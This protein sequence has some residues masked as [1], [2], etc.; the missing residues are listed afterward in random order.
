MRKK[1]TKILGVALPVVLVFALVVGFVPALKSSDADAAAG[2]MRFGKVPLPKYGAAGKY[3]LVSDQNVGPLAVT[4]DGG[5]LFA[6]TNTSGAAF[7]ALLKSS[8]G[9]DSWN[10][11]SGFATAAAAQTDTSTIVSI[12]AS[13]EYGTDTA[14]LVATRNLVYQSVDGGTTFSAMSAP[15]SE[16]ITS[17]DVAMDSSGRLA[18]IVGTSTGANGGEVYVYSPATTGLGWQVQLLAATTGRTC[19]VLAVAFSKNFASDEGIC[20][21]SVNQTTDTRMQWSFTSTKTGGGWGASVGD[22]VFKDYRGLNIIASRASIGLPDD[23]D[24]ASITSNI[25]FVGLHAVDVA[26]AASPSSGVESGDVYR[27][28]VQPSA[29]QAVD[30]NVR[31]LVAQT[32]TATDIWSMDVQGDAAAATILVGTNAVNTGA[33]NYYWASYYSN[34]S[35]STWLT[36]REKAPTGGT[37]T[38]SGTPLA[39]TS[40]S[41]VSCNVLMAPDFDI[42]EMAYAGTSGPDTSAFSRTENGGRSWNQVSFIDYLAAATPYYV[43][44]YSVQDDWATSKTALVCTSN[45]TAGESWGSI[46][47]TTNGGASYQRIWSYANPTATMTILAVTRS[48]VDEEIGKTVFA[49]DYTNGKMWRSTDHGATFPRV[50]T[51]KAAVMAGLLVI[52]PE[53]LFTWYYN[54]AIWTTTTLGRPWDEPEES[55]ISDAILFYAFSAGTLTLVPTYSLSTYLGSVYVSS[56]GGVT[57]TE[58]LGVSPPANGWLS[59]LQTDA[60][61]AENSFVYAAGLMPGA[62]IWR[63]EVDEED[64]SSTEWMQIDSYSANYTTF[65]PTLML[66]KA[67]VTYVFSGNAVSADRTLGG[68]W[69]SVNPDADLTGVNPPM[70]YIENTGLAVGDT[71]AFRSWA[72]GPTTIF[73]YNSAAS[74]YYDQIVAFK[75]IMSAAPTQV[76]PDDG[77]T[78]QGISL[79]TV[80]LTYT[81]ILTWSAV[82]GAQMYEWNIYNDAELTS[83]AFSGTTQGNQ[84]RVDSLIPGRTYYWRVRVSSPLLSPWSAARSFTLAEVEEPEVP[85]AV[86]SPA[87]GATGVSTQPAFVWAKVKD[88]TGYEIV[89]SEDKTFAIIDWSHTSDQNFYQGDEVLAYGTTYYWRVRP[90]DGE[91]TYG[92]FTTMTEPE[93]PTPPV[94]IEPTPPAP[95]VEVT[96][97]EVPVAPAIPNYLLWVIVGVG[98]VLF[99]ALI[100]L[101]LRTR[102]VT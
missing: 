3:A 67:G 63:I 11:L 46:W 92:V 25:A 7:N 18:I 81:M 99:I 17:M 93:E 37:A 41:D 85:F 66:Q 60:N 13:P 59:W 34:D 57:F 19:D 94:V 12:K 71:M 5:I 73:M 83:T 49:S 61:Y 90:A 102:R 65:A 20:A 101:I 58:T 10:M 72:S 28:V 27:V 96:V 48:I 62:G 44:T 95:P 32:W 54:G 82:A 75:D 14:V 47:K 70:F 80:D 78:E 74:N 2:T 15:W 35:G 79:S 91:W 56:D 64:P 68:F 39:L 23:F 87:S 52:T 30:L 29:S 84:M 69:R 16:N 43:K 22:A 38:R 98:G 9:G 26:A 89:V 88:A 55:I 8:D 53:M 76:G 42:N 24:D 100:V 4:P 21:V 6:S 36:P 40:S 77:A 1:L 31:G 50:V 33:A 97:V 86:E 45:G 51:A